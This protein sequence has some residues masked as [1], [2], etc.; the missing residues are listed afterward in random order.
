MREQGFDVFDDIVDHSYQN[1]LD[2][3]DRVYAA[4]DRNLSLLQDFN[5]ASEFI[6]NNQDRLQHNLDLVKTNKFQEQ[7]ATVTDLLGVELLQSKT[8]H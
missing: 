8:N 7:C 2:P 4:V 3:Y 5:R 6:A 1:L